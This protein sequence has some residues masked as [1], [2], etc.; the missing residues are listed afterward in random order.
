MAP[1]FDNTAGSSAR[2]SR[3]HHEILVAAR[4]KAKGEHSD[5]F[6]VLQSG[7][8]DCFK[9]TDLAVGQD[10]DSHLL[11]LTHVHFLSSLKRGDDVCTAVVCVEMLDL[12][13]CILFGVLV[14]SYYSF[15]VDFHVAESTTETVDREGAPDWQTANKKFKRVFCSLHAAH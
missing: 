2:L 6:G 10:K 9:V 1:V 5:F 3:P 15:L 8:L 13:K 4:T 11:T 12:V 7:T 14:V